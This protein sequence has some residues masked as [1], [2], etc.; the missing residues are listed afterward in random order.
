MLEWYSQLD[1]TMQVFWGCAIVGSVIFLI[2]AV[3]TLI[4]MDSDLNMDTDI[5]LGEGDTMD[6]GGGLSLFSIRN[7][8][9]F[10]VGIGWGGICLRS[11]ISNDFL[12]CVV[13][14]LIGCAFVWLYFIIR[15]QT[16][17]LESN[18]AF[19]IKSCEGKIADVYLRIPAEGQGK[20]KVQVSIN[21]SVHEVDA[22][23]EGPELP[24]GAK[25]TVLE[26]KANYLV[27]KG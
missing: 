1:T 20:G 16:R 12:L 24:S 6:L 13:A 26:A 21:G 25:V 14:I 7:L 10:M 23:T 5:D 27:V 11:A 17:K 9:N 8:V 22:V 19:N 2:Q 15:K 4:G 3:L 18:G